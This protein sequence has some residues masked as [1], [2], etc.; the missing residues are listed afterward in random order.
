MTN[1]NQIRLTD[2]FIIERELDTGRETMTVDGHDL[3]EFTLELQS[4]F[5][6]EVEQEILTI[7][8]Q[9]TAVESELYAFINTESSHFVELTDKIT[10]QDSAV[11]SNRRSIDVTSD[12]VDQLYETTRIVGRYLFLDK[13][14]DDRASVD[15]GGLNPGEMVADFE[16]GQSGGNKYKYKNI[17]K[18]YFHTY[19]KLAVDNTPG[20]DPKPEVGKTFENIFKGDILEISYGNDSS[21]LGRATYI[22]TDKE[23]ADP[24][25]TDNL[26]G[27]IEVD[28]IEAAGDTGG[29]FPFSTVD[30]TDD[31]DNPE[32]SS[33]YRV[34][35]FPSV[36]TESFADKTDYESA[37]R[38]GLPVGM[39]VSWFSSNIPDG[40]LPCDGT[41]IPDDSDHQ[42]LILMG[43]T[44]TPDLRGRALIGS[45]ANG[46][47]S[48]NTPIDQ[49]TSKP[50]RT[51]S[52]N[53]KGGHTHTVTIEANGNHSHKYGN[54]SH[55]GGGTKSGAKSAQS[56]GGDYTTSSSGK[57]THGSTVSTAGAHTHTI[58]GWDTYNRMYSHSC[59]FIMKVKHT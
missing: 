24:N 43:I 11:S 52:T 38:S 28:I 3:K 19:D 59:H 25:T 57:H 13:E 58:S 20:V 55:T 14:F 10:S 48:I 34:E 23:G 44:E 42:E 33:T 46:V 54:A 29:G 12:L 36:P 7:A 49:T 18:F 47:S 35:I 39:V 40:W 17:K 32:I 51:P 8:N 6:S 30:A 37:I 2:K 9:A 27:W 45:G 53:S 56:N 21:F 15:N 4:A 5:T 41:N 16:V 1:N 22:V 31:P 50:Q 26:T